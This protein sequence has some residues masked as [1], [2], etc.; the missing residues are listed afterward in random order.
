MLFTVKGTAIKYQVN[1]T[2]NSV[3]TNRETII[4][5]RIQNDLSL[6][7]T[8]KNPDFQKYNIWDIVQFYRNR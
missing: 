3:M 1:V 2:E 4:L 7:Q 8:S 5:K 6:L